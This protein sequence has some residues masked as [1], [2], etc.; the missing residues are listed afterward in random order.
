[1]TTRSNQNEINSQLNSDYSIDYASSKA[2][3]KTL[4]DKQQQLTIVGVSEQ[5][6]NGY[7]KSEKLS[8]ENEKNLTDDSSDS[9]G[10]KMDFGLLKFDEELIEFDQ[11]RCVEFQ[12]QFRADQSFRIFLSQTHSPYR[13]WFHLMEHAEHI[14]TLMNGLE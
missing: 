6:Y 4:N 8:I 12:E 9:I 14:E 7:G 1:M 10:I 13:F 11:L 3:L 5:A 2:T